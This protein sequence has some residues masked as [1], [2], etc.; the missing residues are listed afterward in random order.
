MHKWHDRAGAFA[1]GFF[2]PLPAYKLGLGQIISLPNQQKAYRHQGPTMWSS[3]TV[4][5]LSTRSISWADPHFC[6]FFRKA[7]KFMISTDYRT[8]GS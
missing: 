6:S 4:S 8:R 5:G 3:N 7:Y 1:S 2:L